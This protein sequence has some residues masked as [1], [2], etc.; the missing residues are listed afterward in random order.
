MT[1]IWRI[2]SNVSCRISR[3]VFKVLHFV[4]QFASKP[5]YFANMR[6]EITLEWQHQQRTRQQP[7]V[8]LTLSTS[9]YSW[10][11][12]GQGVLDSGSR[13]SRNRDCLWSSPASHLHVFTHDGSQ[14]WQQW[15]YQHTVSKYD[16]GQRVRN[17]RHMSKPILLWVRNVRVLLRW[18]LRMLLV[19]KRAGSIT[20]YIK[21]PPTQSIK[22][23]RDSISIISLSLP[24]HRHQKNDGVNMSLKYCNSY[25]WP[26]VSMVHWKKW[27]SDTQI[28]NK[29]KL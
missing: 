11:S 28:T 29:I 15:Q 8:V 1:H 21:N 27:Y 26:T 2:V 7:S 6:P 4:N 23:G 3:C 22:R 25:F 24:L 19:Q 12:A 13:Y 9:S 20:D 18:P 14:M 5:C 16:P 10:R 17:R